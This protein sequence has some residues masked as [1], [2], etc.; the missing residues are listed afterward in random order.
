MSVPRTHQR[1]AGHSFHHCIEHLLGQAQQRGTTVHDGLVRVILEPGE[2]GEG[3]WVTVA[4]PAPRGS[5]HH[6]RLSVTH[7]SRQPRHSSRTVVH[8]YSQNWGTRCLPAQH[9]HFGDKEMGP[10]KGG[11]VAQISKSIA[12]LGMAFGELFPYSE[13]PKFL[14]WGPPLLPQGRGKTYLSFEAEIY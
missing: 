2:K 7:K 3:A 11:D 1:C 5:S 6:R 13:L 9:A 10:G 8:S 4:L 12:L 14:H